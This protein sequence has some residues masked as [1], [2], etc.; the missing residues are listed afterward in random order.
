MKL[1]LLIL[2][3][4]QGI[5]EFLP[6]SSSGH[7]LYL[8][9]LLGLRIDR[10]NSVLWLHLATLLAIVVYFYPKIKVLLKDKDYLLKI[11]TAF[12]GT[13]LVALFLRRSVIYIYGVESLNILGL[14]FLINGII[15]FISGLRKSRDKKLTFKFAVL[16]GLMQGFSV[17]PGIS[18]SGITIVVAL[19]LGLTKDEA[20]KFSF[21]LAIPTIIGAVAYESLKSS[22]NSQVF[23]GI[24][25]S[26][27]VYFIVTFI[28]GL[29]ALSLL[30]RMVFRKKLPFFGYYCCIIGLIVLF[31]GG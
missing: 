7:L 17:F 18:R 23:N 1:D 14:L 13:V 26:W 6:V 15:L 27:I 29:L 11:F 22:W 4:V 3:F 25:I 5:A 21:L 8:D 28:V 16:I 31:I 20:F 10:F 9:H 24:N 30:E 2:S 19:L 12:F